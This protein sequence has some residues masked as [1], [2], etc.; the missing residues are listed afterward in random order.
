MHP[1][2]RIT[3]RRGE[4]IGSVEEWGRLA[5]PAS[6]KHWKPDR[7]AYEL[8]SA[9]S[10]GE[11]LAATQR[12]LSRCPALAGVEPQ[13]AIAEAQ[14]RFDAFSGPR[15]HDLL[16]R[17]GEV[18]VSV[19]AKADE[20]FGETIGEYRAAANARRERGEGTKAPERLEG[21]LAALVPPGASAPDSLRYQLFSA[22]AGALAEAQGAR[23]AA[24]VIHEF[25]TPATSPAKRKA[26]SA[27]LRAF[28]ME[29]F[30][31]KPPRATEW[32]IGP[33]RVPGSD[34]IP[35]DVDLYFA[36][37]VT[38]SFQRWTRKWLELAAYQGREVPDVD[39]RIER[40]A[41]L[42]SEPVPGDWRRGADE[43][44]LDPAQRYCR[45]HSGDPRGEHRIEYEVLAATEPTTVLGSSLI[46]GVNAVPLARDEAGGRAGNVEAD[47]LLLIGD[48]GG[49]RQLLVEVK[50]DADHAW[51]AV[52][53]NLRQ[54]RLF[55][56]SE[57]AQAVFR[58]RRS[59]TGPLPVEGL[60]LGPEDF[61]AHSG[62]KQAAV[63]PA[64]RLIERM[65]NVIRVRLATW[66]A[67]K[68]LVSEVPS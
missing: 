9:W 1:A 47:M 38:T 16:I 21:L 60:V 63:R 27:D 15:N 55:E 40:I 5:A 18:I 33:F 14:T 6:Y 26:N 48:G 58:E 28:L 36:K 17:A 10:V 29:L 65:A 52:V 50:V 57:A 62:R 43:R 56:E 32:C 3:N 42:W 11:G 67:A 44:I 8:A 51:Y 20:T 45:T 2:M 59:A 61:F 4:V 25:V 64:Q 54:L 13:A 7:S 22:T 39:E 66:D 46:D 23:A 31:A 37:V 35:G 49:Q 19:E 12:V 41:T 24:V 68:R 30:G 34:R 53:E